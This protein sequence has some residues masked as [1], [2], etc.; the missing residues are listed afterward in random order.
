[1]TN[2]TA[3]L[4]LQL[5]LYKWR[6]YFFALIFITGNLLLPQITHLIPKGGLIFLPIYFFT[7]I[8]SY[9]FGLKVG[10]LTA[11]LSPLLNHFLFGMPPAFVLPAILVKSTLL[12]IIAS[13]VASKFQKISVIHLLVV[14]LA[15]Q[16]PGS[17]VEWAITKS[18]ETAMQDFKIGIPGMLIQIFGG[19]IIL[20]SM[21]KYA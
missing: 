7:L 11:I 20:K 18:F 3:F 4:P 6:T 16:L 10:L 5:P 2:S 13:F 17:M 14:V 12:A 15:Y 19:W 1:M 21:A 9:K 8:A